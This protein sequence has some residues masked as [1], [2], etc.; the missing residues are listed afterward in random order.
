VWD[1][2]RHASS[3]TKKTVEQSPQRLGSSSIRSVLSGG[4][5]TRG[6]N[7]GRVTE[8]WPVIMLP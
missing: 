1:S 6:A 5:L 8:L 2:E 7:G 4:T 3:P